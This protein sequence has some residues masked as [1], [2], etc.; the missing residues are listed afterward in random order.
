MSVTAGVVFVASGPHLF[1]I[2]TECQDDDDVT[3]GLWPFRWVGGGDG[4]GLF[5]L[6]PF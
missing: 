5:M 2:F 1:K 6:L 3:P 4:V